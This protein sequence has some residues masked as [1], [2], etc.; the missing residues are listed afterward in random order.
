[1][2]A[3]Q[4]DGELEIVYMNRDSM[5]SEST[6]ELFSYPGSLI[7]RRIAIFS[8]RAGDGWPMLWTLF[9]WLTKH[10]RRLILRQCKYQ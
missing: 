3:V 5:A 10:D 7:W 4:L 1:M 9:R 6:S 8:R 2:E